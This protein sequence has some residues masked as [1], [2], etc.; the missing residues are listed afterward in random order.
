MK[1]YRKKTTGEVYAFELD[2]SQDFLITAEFEAMTEYE[3]ARHA[4]DNSQAIK[5]AGL[6]VL[7]KIKGLFG[8]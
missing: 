2:G 5:A 4:G 7:D 1:Y 3:I 8:A 6:S